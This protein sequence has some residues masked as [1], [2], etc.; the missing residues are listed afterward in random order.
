MAVDLAVDL[1]VKLTTHPRGLV[2]FELGAE[3]ER[4]HASGNQTLADVG[5]STGHCEFN[6]TLARPYVGES[7]QT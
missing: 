2:R 5:G 6:Q 1:V 4:A 7:N 3:A